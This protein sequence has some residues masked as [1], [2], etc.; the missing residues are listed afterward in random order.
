M[1]VVRELVEGVQLSLVVVQVPSLAELVAALVNRATCYS[2]SCNL[3]LIYST[4]LA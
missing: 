3:F 1:L 2:S 4:T